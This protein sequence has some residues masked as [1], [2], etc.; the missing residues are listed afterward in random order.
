M[1]AEY[2]AGT[3]V[4]ALAKRYGISRKT[5]AE[6]ARRAGVLHT[7]L[8]ITG[9]VLAQT[10][11]MYEAGMGL[12]RIASQLR[13]SPQR[14]RD[15]LTGAGVKIRAQQG[16]RKARQGH[17]GSTPGKVQPIGVVEAGSARVS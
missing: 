2:T 3:P 7:P 17:A 10:V 5:V 11:A 16:G 1:L 15:A 6:H 4:K 9:D 8:E 12:E 13:T 14:V